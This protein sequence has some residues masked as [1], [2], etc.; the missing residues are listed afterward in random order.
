MAETKKN[1]AQPGARKKGAAAATRKTPAKQSTK[2]P[3]ARRRG[4]QS[5][6]S[7]T[8]KAATPRKTAQQAMK[9]AQETAKAASE[10]VKNLSGSLLP[11]ADKKKSA[12]SSGKGKKTQ[13]VFAG[14]KLRKEVAEQYPETWARIQERREA[15]KYLGINL[16]EDVLPM[17]N[18]N[19]AM[20]PFMLNTTK[21]FALEEA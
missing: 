13:Q 9:M 20:F 3:A 12:K 19:A 6:A 10:A 11:A 8:T 5:A 7:K 4:S 17:S 18:M 16:H 2:M 21:V 1:P 14:E 15:M